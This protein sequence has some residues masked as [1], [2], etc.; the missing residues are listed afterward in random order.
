MG[1]YFV[2]SQHTQQHS[3]YSALGHEIHLARWIVMDMLHKNYINPFEDVI[4]TNHDDRK[5]IYTKIFSHVLSW[6]E[7]N[8]EN[9][10][11]DRVIISIWPF[12]VSTPSE[13]SESDFMVFE[14]KCSYPIRSLFYGPFSRDYDQLLSMIDYPPVESPPREFFIVHLRMFNKPA[15]LQV[16]LNLRNFY[17]ILSFLSIQYPENDVIVF[18][19]YKGDLEL[20]DNVRLID[21]LDAYASFMNHDKCMAV[22]SPISGG[23][24]FAQYCHRKHIHI[25]PSDY[26]Y[27]LTGTIPPGRFHSDWWSRCTTGASVHHYSRLEDCLGNLSNHLNATQG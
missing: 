6:N 12:V 13:L 8:I 16:E 2:V 20:G 3:A 21:Q 15:N 26:T 11:G 5:F 23:G 10:K 9:L 24:E 27:T 14:Q 19:V 17:Q 18:T 7:F 1:R 25:Y 22:I 4:V